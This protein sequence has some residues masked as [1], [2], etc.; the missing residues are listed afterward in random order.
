L[1]TSQPPSLK[2]SFGNS[3]G[4]STNYYLAIHLAAQNAKRST[5]HLSD[6]YTAI[7]ITNELGPYH[8]ILRNHS[9]S[10]EF[11]AVPH[12]N[13]LYLAK[14]AFDQKL[15]KQKQRRAPVIERWKINRKH[16][17]ELKATTRQKR[18]SRKRRVVE[19]ESE[20]DDNQDNYNDNES[21]E[22]GT[23]THQEKQIEDSEAEDEETGDHMM[24]GTNQE[25]QNDNVGE[26]GEG[27]DNI[28]TQVTEAIS[29]L[30]SGNTTAPAG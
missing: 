15:Q 4:N 24:S 30:D 2:V 1:K 5:L 3:L 21:V 7:E 12:I 23:R 8:Q 13:E 19:S 26:E 14:Y 25:E 11:L 18:K 20:N 17:A 16:A 10:Q 22:L 6:I 27:M 28:M 29:F 9:H